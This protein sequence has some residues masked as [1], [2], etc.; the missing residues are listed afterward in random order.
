MDRAVYGIRRPL[1]RWEYNEIY[2]Q[3][4]LDIDGRRELVSRL[5]P[6]MDTVINAFLSFAT[7]TPGFKSLPYEDKVSA[8]RRMNQLAIYTIVLLLN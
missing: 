2:S 7:S 8:I 1:C 4:G 6:I 3:T 5:I